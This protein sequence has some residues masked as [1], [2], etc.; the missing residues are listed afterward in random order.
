MTDADL[1]AVAARQLEL[2][3]APPTDEDAASYYDS[4][5]LP[6]NP[7]HGD[8]TVAPSGTYRGRGLFAARDFTEGE[9]VLREPPR[10]GIQQE[11][12]RCDALVCAECF[13]YVG[14]IER[15]IATRLLHDSHSDACEG[16]VDRRV[17]EELQSGVKSLPDSRD[18]PMPECFECHGGCDR[19]VYCS[20]ACTSNAWSR[21]ER[22]LCVGPVGGERG[23][24]ATAFVNH[25]KETNDIFPLAA[26][27]L[28]ETAHRAELNRF[29]AVAKAKASNNGSAEIEPE[30]DV[31]AC[32]NDAWRP[33]AV[34][35]K[36]IWWEEVSR[37]ADVAAGAAEVEFRNSMKE[38]AAESLDLLRKILAHSDP[39]MHAR[40]PGLFTI[41]VYARVIGM[42]E[43]NNLEIAVASHVEDYFLAMDDKYADDSPE[44]KVTGPLLDALDV[45]YCTPCE[46]TGFFALQSCVNSDCDPNVTPLKD[47][48]DRDGACVLVRFFFLIIVWEFRD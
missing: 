34:A 26:R 8:V 46:G 29:A 23:L 33:Y 15:Q 22:H 5:L 14:S 45:G 41:D 9:R 47:D 35:H 4:L 48:D 36:G 2:L 1:D 17:L 38:I 10:V 32:L 40:Y 19:N 42:F 31:D 13:R 44:R 20:D 28:L 21:H 12:N 6:N 24:A 30:I 18:F 11:H 3:L 43:L 27:V 39:A 25:A 37:P 7:G 16:V